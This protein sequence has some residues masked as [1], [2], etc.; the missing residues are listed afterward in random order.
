M[1]VSFHKY[2]NEFLSDTSEI[3]CNGRDEGKVFAINAPLLQEIDDENY[4]YF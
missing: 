4:N 2:G 3:F 1:T